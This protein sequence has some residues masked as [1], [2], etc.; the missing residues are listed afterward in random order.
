MNV[1]AL[2]ENRAEEESKV[3]GSRRNSIDSNRSCINRMTIGGKAPRRSFDPSEAIRELKKEEG[4]A[5]W[6]LENQK[7]VAAENCCPS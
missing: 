1:P 4:K 5:D 7:K 6:T 2:P 3:I